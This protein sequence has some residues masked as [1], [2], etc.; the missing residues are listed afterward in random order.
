MLENIIVSPL[1]IVTE[2]PHTDWHLENL[3]RHGYTVA[4][5]ITKGKVFDK[6]Q[7]QSP[8][9]VRLLSVIIGIGYFKNYDS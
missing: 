7:A 9:N 4:Y 8:E 1:C 3:I 2:E 6:L 5:S